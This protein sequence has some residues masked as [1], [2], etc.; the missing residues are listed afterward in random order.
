MVGFLTIA[1]VSY[2]IGS[3]PSGY[4][5]GRLAGVDIR[6]QGSGNIGATNVTRTLGKRYGYPVF[7]ADFC[8]G[9][10]AILLAPFL[11]PAVV[12]SY[13]P[14]VAQIAAGI[15]VVVGNAFPLWLRFRGGKGVATSAGLLF[16]LIP[17]AAVVVTLIW[18]IAFYTIRYVSLASILAALSLPLA[19][20]II[21]RLTGP[22]RPLVLYVSIA[23]AAIVILRHRSNLS[24]LMHGTEERF[25]RHED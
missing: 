21:P 18:V 1:F 17:A 15:F 16:G 7:L 6:T 24:R 12:Q 20:F 14:D 8:K 22:P 25:E 9:L 4:L 2:L 3:I 11:A 10:S 5:A 13:Q 19:A 23:L